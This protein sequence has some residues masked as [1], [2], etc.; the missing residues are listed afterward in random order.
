M[1][2]P[3]GGLFAHPVPSKITPPCVDNGKATSEIFAYR[4]VEMVWN[5][6]GIVLK[7]KGTARKKFLVAY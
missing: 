4:I 6:T 2:R 7:E 1:V 5:S 3:E